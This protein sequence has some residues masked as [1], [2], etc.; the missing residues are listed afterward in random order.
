MKKLYILAFFLFLKSA[1]F[2]QSFTLSEAA[3][4]SILTVGPGEQLYDKFGHSAFRIN[5]PANGIDIVYNYGVYDF[6]TPNFYTKFARGKLLY[7]LGVSY[8]EPFLAMYIAQN[9]WVKEQTLELSYV[10]KRAVFNY[11]QENALPEN[12][13]YK[14]D[15]FYDNCAT[16]IR[17]VLVASLGDAI[18][19]T[20]TYVDEPHTFRELIQQNV[21][22]NSWGSLGMD[23]AI[24][25]VVDIEASPWEHQFLPEYIFEAAKAATIQTP[26]G[27]QPLVAET[28]VLFQNTPKEE[29]T[30]F[31]TSPLFVFMLI[32]MFILGMT[33]KD[34]RK[35]TRCRRLDGILFFVTGLIGFF[36]LLLWL[37]TDHTATA[38]NY[39]MLWAFPVNLLLAFYMA[40]RNP[41]V[42][43]RRY[44]IFL[45]LLLIMVVIHWFTGVQEFAYA[46]IPLFVA[47]AVR[48]VFVIN[49]LK[50]QTL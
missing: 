8:Y 44:L 29:N 46:F 41:P 24:G 4:V 32:A 26:A 43:L 7:K 21:Y 33:M 28:K 25:A 19:Y 23:V 16:K 12:Q 36:L 22:W 9:R 10:Q 48:Y 1:V 38:N 6:D 39:N 30:H 5:D 2:A 18:N 31:F 15:F 20:D 45:L 49:Y 50:K 27:S 11:L 34:I 3:E 47:M 14:Y 35:N 40:K 13:Y 37:A 17:D 42:W